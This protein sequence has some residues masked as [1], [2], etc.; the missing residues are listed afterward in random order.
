[1]MPALKLLNIAEFRHGAGKDEAMAT[2]ETLAARIN[3]LSL[4]LQEIDW[5]LAAA[6]AAQV[7]DA[8]RR[9]LVQ[10]NDIAMT[11]QADEA[12]SL[13]LAALLGGLAQRPSP[14]APPAPCRLHRR[15]RVHA[16]NRCTRSRAL[17][18]PRGR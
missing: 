8:L 2:T 13:E 11:P 3:V 9:R 16:Q 7:T 12:A 17:S 14:R 5:A 15:C 4:G 10:L 1:M 18:A 6:Q